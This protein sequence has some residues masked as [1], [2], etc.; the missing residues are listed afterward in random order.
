MT[1]PLSVCLVASSVTFHDTCDHHA[2]LY[3]SHHMH[4]GYN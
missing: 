3:P 4:V 2:P 1:L